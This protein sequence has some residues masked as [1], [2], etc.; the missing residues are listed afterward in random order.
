MANNY[1]VVS[2]ETL[3]NID[4]DTIFDLYQPILGT[5]GVGVYLTLLHEE[6][7]LKKLNNIKFDIKRLHKITGLTEKQFNDA[8]AKLSGMRLITTS[9]NIKKSIQRFSILAPLG[10]ED[11]FG[12]AIYKKAL[13]AKLGEENVEALSFLL[14]DSKETIIEDE[15][16]ETTNSFVD[17]FKDE[18]TNIADV[19]PETL[20]VSFIS[21]SS[22]SKKKNLF[23]KVINKDSLIQELK[24]YAIN[25]NL[26]DK[27]TI[28]QLD[29]IVA[30]KSFNLDQLARIIVRS[31]DHENLM[32]DNDLIEKEIQK[33]IATLDSNNDNEVFEPSIISKALE[34]NLNKPEDFIENFTDRKTER[35]ELQMIESLKNKGFSNGAINALIDYSFYK[36]NGQIVANYILK[37]AA[38]L[39]EKNITETKKVM[40]YLKAAK[41][42]VERSNFSKIMKTARETKSIKLEEDLYSDVQINVLENNSKITIDEILGISK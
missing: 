21:L 12:N 32:L 40:C 14:K 1:T 24:K 35:N 8:I 31:Y 39:L 26:K 3:S 5:T 38:T 22:F 29:S 11:F 4:I 41:N 16:T 23:E 33:E 34:F 28:N 7:T 2:K 13:I 36:N 30:F 20:K 25:L 6:K 37:I 19:N 17:V 42:S 9:I 18:I 27:K 15:W 10:V